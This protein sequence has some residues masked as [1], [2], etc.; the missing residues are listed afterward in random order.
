MSYKD[1][2]H[3]CIEEL[4]YYSKGCTDSINSYKNTND[5]LQGQRYFYNMYR[6]TKWP[7]N[8]KK[9][10]TDKKKQTKNR[11]LSLELTTQLQ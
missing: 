2:S 5:I 10:N 1:T 9:I 4:I 11:Y 3:S 6:N 7:E 8:P